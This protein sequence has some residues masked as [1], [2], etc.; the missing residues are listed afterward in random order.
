[1]DV[2][3]AVIAG[4][5]GTAVMTLLMTMAPMMGMPKMDIMNMLGT[6]VTE[7]ENARLVGGLIHFVMGAIFGLIY[8]F[9]WSSVIGSPT[10]VWGLVFGLVHGVIT[11]VTMPMMMNMHPRPPKM[12]G[13]M[14][15]AVGQLLGHAVFGI[16]V[17]L[18]Y[19]AL[20]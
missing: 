15:T 17:A 10:L 13:G 6:M 3:A 12:E 18:T 5:L 19:A 9:L 20:T 11:M 4:L 2:V 1:M 14:M 16:V 8:A 7:G